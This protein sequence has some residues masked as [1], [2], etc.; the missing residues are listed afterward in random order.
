LYA[1]GLGELRDLAGRGTTRAED[2][3]GTP[4]QSHT[5][6]SVLVYEDTVEDCT[7]KAWESGDQRFHICFETFHSRLLS[8]WAALKILNGSREAKGNRVVRE[9]SGSAEVMFSSSE[10]LSLIIRGPLLACKVW[11]CTRKV[12]E[13]GDHVLGEL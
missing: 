5:S 11:G 3:Q 13:S 12:W 8:R 6:P 7:R 2:A 4:T 9:R 1:K 10:A